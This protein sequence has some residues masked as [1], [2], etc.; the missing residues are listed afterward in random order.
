MNTKYNF[1]L[2]NTKQLESLAFNALDEKIDDLPELNSM[3]EDI[4]NKDYKKDKY[5]GYILK[6]IQILK[7]IKFDGYILLLKE[8]NDTAEQMQIYIKFFGNIQNSLISFLLGFTEEYTLEN[9][10]KFINFIP[11]TKDPVI[12]III[13][14]ER[15]HE[16][17][18][19]IKDKYKNMITNLTYKSIEFKEPLKLNFINLDV[20]IKNTLSKDDAIKL[21]FET[22][23]VNINF[24]TMSAQITKQNKILLGFD[25][26]GLGE[27]AVNKILK[28]R[29]GGLERLFKNFED[30][31]R[32][33]DMSIFTDIQ[34][35]KLTKLF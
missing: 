8:L 29:E 28:E 26:L 23:S 20:D 7:L 15:K 17:I 16:L 30:F 1:P 13:E 18:N 33:I 3:Y 10:K 2:E 6:E 21:G 25:S 34:I 31:Q 35:E 9:N 24:S 19:H 14:N 32:R 4:A 12:N 27:V 11:F 5:K 22:E